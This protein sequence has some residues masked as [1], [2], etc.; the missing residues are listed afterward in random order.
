MRTLLCSIP[1]ELNG[2]R[3]PG[4]LPSLSTAG[5]ILGQLTFPSTST[6]VSNKRGHYNSSPWPQR[7][8][9]ECIICLCTKGTKLNGPFIFENLF[10]Q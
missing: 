6:A 3:A 2:E 10:F 8:Q 4:W 9:I 5:R 7:Y 1:Q